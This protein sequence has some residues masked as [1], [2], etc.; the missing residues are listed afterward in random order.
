MIDNVKEVA[1]SA[2]PQYKKDT[3][4]YL[5]IP[6][7]GKA[8][9]KLLAWHIYLSDAGHSILCI[10]EELEEKAFSGKNEPWNYLVPV[11]VQ[12]AQEGFEVKHGYILPTDARLS[13]SNKVGLLLPDGYD[14][15]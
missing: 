8:N 13:Y 10:I 11:P 1:A 6:Y 5:D 12:L 14:E 7:P 2:I 15:F 9:E 4:N 3:P